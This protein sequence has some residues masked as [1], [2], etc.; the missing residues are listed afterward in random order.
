MS[1]E[2]ND[3]GNEVGTDDAPQ[4]DSWFEPVRRADRPPA[5]NG[6]AGEL[7]DLD[8]VWA[9]DGDG[10]DGRPPAEWFLRMGRAGLLPESMTVS[11]DDGEATGEWRYD[12]AGSPPWAGD[13]VVTDGE[14][15]P[16]ESG[17]WPEPGDA[18]T[19][20][21]GSD[22]GVPRPDGVRP[23]A[24]GRLSQAGQVAAPPTAAGANWQ[25]RAAL[26]T[27]LLPLVVPGIVLGVLGLRRSKAVGYGQAAS[28]AGIALSVVWAVVLGFL[29]IGSGGSPAAG[30]SVPRAV[31]T[32]YA[33]VMKDFSAGAAASAQSAD[34][35]AA[36]GQANAAAAS[37]AQLPLRSALFALARDLEQAQSDLV[38][39]DHTVSA[40]LRRKLGADSSALTS[41]CKS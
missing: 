31:S 37:A 15:P 8:A 9:G 1:S 29:V 32:S 27:G 30:C 38:G 28:L 4:Q 24:Q 25:A 14:P 33:Q 39:H 21:P 6:H 40:T 11:S 17:P 10:T 20:T 3:P 23:A 22:D 34:V 19:R 36:A 7:G 13:V 2:R 41:A 5:G 26:I 16:W 35:T 18:R 12:A